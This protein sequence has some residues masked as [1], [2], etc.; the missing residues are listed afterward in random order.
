MEPL[1]FN[2]PKNK[3]GTPIS[4]NCVIWASGNI[5]CIKL[6]DTDTIGDVAFKLGQGLCYTQSLLDLT[7][8]DL[9]CFYTP[10]PSCQQPTKLLDIL[11]IMVNKICSQEA[12]IQA[13]SVRI[14]NLGG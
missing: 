13:L 6:C 9:S 1:V 2:S 12:E 8:L 11:Q 4:T 3:C 14:T 5:P 7:S 10:C